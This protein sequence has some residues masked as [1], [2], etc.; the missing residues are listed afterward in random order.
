MYSVV[1]LAALSATEKALAHGWMKHHGYGVC[2]GA[3]YGNCYAGWPHAYGGWGLPYGGYW[4]GYGCYMPHGGPAFG[5]HSPA[6][7]PAPATYATDE[8]KPEKKDEPAKDKKDIEPKKKDKDN[9][10]NKT[11]ARAR[12]V[13][14]M[15]RGASLYVD[16]QLI[17]RADERKAFQ[18]PP[19]ERGEQYYYELRVEVLRDGRKFV[20]NRKVTLAAGETVRAD[21]STVGT[22]TG[23]ATAER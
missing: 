12:L 13:F 18:T 1:L 10:D 20:E 6:F 23:V 4:A 22:T 15:P 9:T 14:E 2:Y 17:E 7:S 11:Q 5:L 3:C 16:G 19:L 8:A 21:F